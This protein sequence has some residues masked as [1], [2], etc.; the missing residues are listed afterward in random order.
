MLSII[1]KA[2]PNSFDLLWVSGAGDDLNVID[3]FVETKA[4][5]KWL[6]SNFSLRCSA[7]IKREQW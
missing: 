4:G 7:A 3:L 6:L 5:L 1:S 2:L